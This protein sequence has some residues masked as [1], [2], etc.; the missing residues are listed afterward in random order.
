MRRKDLLGLEKQQRKRRDKNLMK[1][2]F[3]TAEETVIAGDT[4]VLQT[5]AEDTIFR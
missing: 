3:Q 2:Q 5:G 4:L 1:K